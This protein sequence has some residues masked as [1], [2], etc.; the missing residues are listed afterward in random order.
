MMS[1]SLTDI[2]P[3]K[4][5]MARWIVTIKDGHNWICI[6]EYPEKQADEIV[7]SMNRA[8]VETFKR[9]ES[10]LDILCRF[11]DAFCGYHDV[12]WDQGIWEMATQLTK[13]EIS[14]L[15]DHYELRL[16]EEEMI[17]LRGLAK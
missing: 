1:D 6:G 5:S 14:H 16:D 13:E 17:E 2:L 12:T 15:I 10:D 8:G 11:F 9:K 3:S 4:S 7:M